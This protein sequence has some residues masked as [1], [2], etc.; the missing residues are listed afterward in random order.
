MT[1]PPL[2][3]HVAPHIVQDLGLN[4]YTTLSR[5][6]GEFVPSAYDADSPSVDITFDGEEIQ[7]ARELLKQEWDLELAERRASGRTTEDMI[8]LEER[9]LPSKITIEVADFGHGMS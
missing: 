1:D 4:L 2:R 5:V 3:F 6:L 8:P 9:T 7:R